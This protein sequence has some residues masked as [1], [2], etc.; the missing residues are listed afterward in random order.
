VERREEY[1]SIISG[2]AGVGKTTVGLQFMKEAAGRGEHSV[3]YTFEDIY[4]P[5]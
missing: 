2:P 4:V 5:C 1:D 3:I